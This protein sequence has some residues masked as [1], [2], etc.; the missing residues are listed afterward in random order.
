M[1]VQSKRLNE[2][3]VCCFRSITGKG[4]KV[5]WEITTRCNLS[6]HHCMVYPPVRPGL[7]PDKMLRTADEMKTMNVKKVLISGGEPFL[8]PHL[9]KLCSVISSAGILVDINT[10]ATL[11]TENKL[12][13][14]M[15]RGVN[16]LTISLDGSSA[17]VYETCRPGAS[18]EKVIQNIAAA[19]AMGF[20]VDIVFVPTRK[21]VHQLKEIIDLSQKLGAMSL[22]IAG[23]VRFQKAGENWD[24]L[25]LEESQV[26]QLYR[27]INTGRRESSI[28]IRTNRVFTPLP[29]ERCGVGKT[30]LAIDA[31]GYVHPCSLYILPFAPFNDLLNH[32]PGEIVNSPRF[33]A[34][35]PSA[36]DLKGCAPCRYRKKCGGGCPGVKQMDRVP[37]NHPDPI[38][39]ISHEIQNIHF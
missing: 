9:E 26:L 12:K 6:C 20:S 13:R 32:T 16:E 25:K 23:L 35:L 19:A 29:P 31:S 39:D 14:L 7:P 2:D 11:F 28:P 21:N 37:L 22:T 3:S 33:K 34:A 10:N 5:C 15:D 24:R 18:F 4:I 38:C 36:L 1:N 8:F 17:D 27:D 30:V